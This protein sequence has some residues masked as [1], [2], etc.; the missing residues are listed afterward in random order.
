MALSDRVITDRS[1]AYSVA[2]AMRVENVVDSAAQMRRFQTLLTPLNDDKKGIIEGLVVS[3]TTD[4]G[5]PDRIP[6]AAV[7]PP[8][9]KQSLID[10]A[11]AELESLSPDTMTAPPPTR[12]RNAERGGSGHQGWR[13]GL[14]D[15]GGSIPGFLLLDTLIDS[16]P[17]R[18]EEV[19]TEAVGRTVVDASEAVEETVTGAVRQTKSALFATVESSLLVIISVVLVVVILMVASMPVFGLWR[20]PI[21]V[22]LLTALTAYAIYRWLRRRARWL[23][24]FRHVNDLKT[25]WRELPVVLRDT[26]VSFAALCAGGDPRPWRKV[27][28]GMQGN[29]DRKGFWNQAFEANIDNLML[30]AMELAVSRYGDIAD[31]DAVFRNT[32]YVEFPEDKYKETYLRSG[33]SWMARLRG[34]LGK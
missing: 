13:R 3:M 9:E 25:V 32:M 34:A 26:G 8:D 17:F 1:S 29:L 28:A 30:E 2:K 19:A 24:G 23:I 5:S 14:R 31:A 6:D 27:K 4:K 21:A 10:A 20:G 15:L 22:G 16:V 11:M 7:L 12:N 18:S 33:R